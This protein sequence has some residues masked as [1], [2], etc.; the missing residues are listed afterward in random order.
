MDYNDLPLDV[1]RVNLDTNKVLIGESMPKLPATLYS[2]LLAKL[3]AAVTL[4]M[5]NQNNLI[6][7][8]SDQ[9][10]H[11]V[12]IDPEEAAE[13]DYLKIRD[14]MLELMTSLLR[15]YEKLIVILLEE[16]DSA[17]KWKYSCRT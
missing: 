10:F 4:A 14:A 1:M 16:V 12:F 8:S 6:L 9:V 13:F 15:G 11:G 5:N 3:K 17:Y 7:Q 2:T